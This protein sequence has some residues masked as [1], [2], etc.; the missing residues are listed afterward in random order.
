MKFPDYQTYQKLYARYLQ[1]PLTP[2]FSRFD[3]K[4]K[5]VLDLCCGDG[6]LT[7]L[8]LELGANWV[9]MVDESSEML[10]QAMRKGSTH[11]VEDTV[12][13]F[14]HK[15][16]DAFDLIVCR[17]GVNHWLKHVDCSLLAKALKPNGMFVFNTFGRR[18]DLKP[19]VRDYTLNGV[20]YAEL[21]YLIGDTIHHVQAATGMEPHFCTFKWIS[22]EE[23]QAK[24]TPCFYT[25]EIVDGASSMWYCW[26]KP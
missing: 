4:G 23:F 16:N 13:N 26:R 9:T 8:A 11:F 20:D 21:S 24:L 10:N 14:L 5:D 22:N 19:R 7:N 1:K 6:R 18:P 3:V 15:P 12:E 17:Q 25:T 2:F